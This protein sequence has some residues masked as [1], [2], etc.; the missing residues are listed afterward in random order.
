MPV[1]DKDGLQKA[2]DRAGM[3]PF[4]LATEVKIS[5]TY[6]ADILSGRRTLKRNPDLRHRIAEALDCPYKWI[7]EEAVAS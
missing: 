5:R 7:E 4:Q 1:I 2:M 6:L 3:K